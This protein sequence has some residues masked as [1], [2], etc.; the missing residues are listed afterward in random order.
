MGTS[1]PVI[2]DGE[3]VFTTKEQRG[4]EAYEGIRRVDAAGRNR[5]TVAIASQKAGYLK[6][7]SGGGVAMKQEQIV[8]LDGSVGFSTAPATA[9][10]GKAN[11]HVGVNSVARG[12]AFQGSR[13]SISK[14]S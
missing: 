8:M 5:D 1:A 12:W 7:N 4:D 6:A 14:G 3:M 10:L 2:L 11:S 13:V 9:Q